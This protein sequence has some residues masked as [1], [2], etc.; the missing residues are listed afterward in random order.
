LKVDANFPGWGNVL[1]GVQKL[2][3]S[4]Q[5]KAQEQKNALQNKINGGINAIAGNLSKAAGAVA[6]RLGGNSDAVQNKINGD[7]DK[8]KGAVNCFFGNCK[9]P[10]G[11]PA[12]APAQK[13]APSGPA[14]QQPLIQPSLQIPT[15]LPGGPNTPVTSISGTDADKNHPKNVNDAA[16][17]LAEFGPGGNSNAKPSTTTTSTDTENFDVK[18]LPSKFTTETI[19]TTTTTE[20]VEQKPQIIETIIEEEVNK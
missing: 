9:K 12:P 4:I 14:P 19:T 7:A 5:N 11:G 18:S 2:G 16:D 1:S 13:P 15:S 8:L 20:V 10:A 17:D 3:N 6:G